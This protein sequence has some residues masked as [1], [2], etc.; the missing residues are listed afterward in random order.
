MR[1][2]VSIILAAMIAVAL[3]SC[4][5]RTGNKGDG[6]MTGNV[7]DSSTD[8]SDRT[9]SDTDA[10]TSADSGIEGTD[11]IG[12]GASGV[13][14]AIWDKY[15]ED[16]KFASAGGDMENSVMNG[17]GSFNVG[18]TEDLDAT[19]GLP[20]ALA[21]SITDAASLMH[22]MNANTFTSACYKL[23]EGTNVKDFS[24]TLRK[25][26]MA[27]QWICGTPETYLAMNVNDEYIVSAFG[28]DDLIKTFKT[29]AQKAIG[30][31]SVISEEPIAE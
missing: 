7:T 13:L 16:E 24:E 29:N 2:I 4:G 26:I 10:D 15:G 28:A 25:N 18:N 1:K 3:V 31:V 23:K 12:G 22:M 20:A 11:P 27:R 6:D 5:D 30:T 8:D 14:M 9:D 17:P 19:L 21:G